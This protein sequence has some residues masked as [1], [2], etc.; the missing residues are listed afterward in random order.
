MAVTTG[1][2]V[3]DK[4]YIDGKWVDPVG[5]E[6]IDVVNA[7]TEEVMARIPQ[8][9]PEDV[10]R[11]VSAARRAFEGWAQTPLVERAEMLR[12]ITAGLAARSDEIASTIA[13]ELGMP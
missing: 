13:Q 12:A 1:I 7:S 3:K 6:T 4:L 11:A 5:D 10:D 9:T 2:Q 8:G